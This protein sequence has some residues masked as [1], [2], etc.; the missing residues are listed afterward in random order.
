[1]EAAEVVRG[2]PLMHPA[3]ALPC[4]SPRRPATAPDAH[5]PVVIFLASV[6]PLCAVLAALMGIAASTGR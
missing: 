5:G 2:H 4:W 6:R 3:R 1:M